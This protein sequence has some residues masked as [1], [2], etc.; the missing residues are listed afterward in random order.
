L[1]EHPVQ[2][3][4]QIETLGLTWGRWQRI[5]ADVERLGYAGLYLC[6]H[7]AAPWPGDIVTIDA[8]T[9]LTYLADHSQRLRFGPLVSPLS[10]RDP[11]ILARQA[12]DLDDLSGGRF[13]LGVGAGW[14][15][16][17]HQMFGWPLGDAKTRVDRLAEG[18]EVITRLCRSPEP[19]SFAG[20]FYTLRDAVLLPRS[21]RPNGPEVLLGSGGG[22]RSVSL[23]ARYADVFN[24]SRQTAAKLAE[25]YRQLDARLT[26]RGRESSSVKRTVMATVMTWRDDD[27]L[28]RRTRFGRTYLNPENLAPREY[29]ESR[30]ARGDLVGAPEEVVEQI[31][32][33]AELGVQEIMLD[34][35]DLDDVE[36]LELIADEVIP[37]L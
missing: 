29:A 23:A 35:F 37:R 16:R 20:R 24:T 18:L 26:A 31:R 1:E 3:S 28:E 21:R 4:V 10:F 14:V 8:W 5:I 36:L 32:A 33:Y 15:E 17:E 22:S 6:D 2:L 30:R 12:M 9:A 11:I 13:V 7:F 27:G 25:I 34:V 19:V